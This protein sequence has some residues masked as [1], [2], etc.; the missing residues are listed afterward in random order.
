MA[1]HP[2]FT[3]D[4]EKEILDFF[5]QEGYAVVADALAV[6]EIAFLN[7]F[8]DRSKTEIP[9]EWGP[10]KRG[11]YSHG[12][13]LVN[14]PE[15]DHYVQYETTFPLIDEIMGPGARFAQYDFRDIP[16][17]NGDS[18]MDYHKDDL[19]YKPPQPPEV[20][21]YG[22]KYLC[23][24]YHL[25]DVDASTP[26]FCVVPKSGPYASIEEAQQQLGE[27]YREVPITGPAGTAVLYDIS[28]FHRRLAGEKDK[29]RR[30]QHNY[31]SSQGN[32]P[33]TSWV[34]IPERLAEHPEP[35][36][37]EYFSAWPE[38]TQTFADQGYTAEFYREHVVGKPT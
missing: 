5:R 31:F 35:G 7:D 9:D 2:I 28:I 34:L 3:P 10:D 17:G 1:D 6:D 25:S 19:N 16:P 23:A 36:L 26:R 15:L 33:L 22:C 27:A 12:Q 30:T 24:I 13:V 37:C 32:P 21:P 38:G 18:A 29:G 20:G 14:H 4:Q 8:V 11:C